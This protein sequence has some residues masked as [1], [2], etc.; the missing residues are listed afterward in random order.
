[1]IAHLFGGRRNDVRDILAC[2]NL[3]KCPLDQAPAIGAKFRNLM[4]G[5]FFSNSLAMVR[6][7]V[8]GV[9]ERE[10]AFFFGTFDE[11]LLAVGSVIEG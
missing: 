10:Q 2:R 9:A 7:Q 8:M 3:L 1:M 4:N 11:D 5:Y 6:N